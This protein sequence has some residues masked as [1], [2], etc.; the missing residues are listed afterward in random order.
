MLGQED[1]LHLNVYTPDLPITE[2]QHKLPVMVWIFG[3]SI[4]RVWWHAVLHAIV[5]MS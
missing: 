4:T 1:C 2:N 5:Y 3:K